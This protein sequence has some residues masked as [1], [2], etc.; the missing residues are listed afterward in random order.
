M[1][2][3]SNRSPRVLSRN[4]D[5]A[6]PTLVETLERRVLLAADGYAAA[7]FDNTD[8]TGTSGTRVDASLN[9]SSATTLPAGVSGSFSSRW[10]TQY[11]FANNANYLF[12]A[13]VSD[14]VR[15]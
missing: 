9:L 13:T 3:R 7:Y 14:G 2:P 1:V 10:S 4:L 8:F 5:S 11:K 6:G 12:R 15:V